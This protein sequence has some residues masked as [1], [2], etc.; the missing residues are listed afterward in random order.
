MNTLATSRS[1]RR[2]ALATAAT[3]V[4]Q[5]FAGLPARAAGEVSP[6][7]PYYDFV[8]WVSLAR[9]DAA[10][11]Q[12]ADDATVVAGP[13]CTQEAP[14][15]GKA[16]IR[17]RYL[18]SLLARRVGA[19]VNDQRFDGERLRTHREVVRE[20]SPHE[21]ATRLIGGHSF[22][23]RHG[24]IASLRFELDVTDPQTAAFVARRAAEAVLARR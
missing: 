22:E 21:C 8:H 3:A 16:A 24:R 20:L 18:A 4:A 11:E 19:P 23:F 14:C 2:V 6:V 12:F 13:S 7:Q 5:T 17:E 1:L 15:V 10:L 9:I